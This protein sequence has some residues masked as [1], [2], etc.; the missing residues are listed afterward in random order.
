MPEHVEVTINGESKFNSKEV[1]GCT[2]ERYYD[3]VKRITTVRIHQDEGVPCGL[4]FSVGEADGTVHQTV[5]E[6][7]TLSSNEPFTDDE[8]EG[9]AAYIRMLRTVRDHKR[10][11]KNLDAK[12]KA[13]E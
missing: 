7:I 9:L 3:G 6:G 4:D 2:I 5:V 8:Q 13:N 12:R 10:G 1:S 11:I